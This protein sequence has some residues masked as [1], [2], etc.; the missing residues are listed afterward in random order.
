[1]PTDADSESDA[2]AAA[3]AGS[4]ADLE[5]ESAADLETDRELVAIVA[6]A[7]NGVIGRDGEMPWHLPEDLAHFKETTTDHPVIMGRVTYEGIL[8]TLGEPLPGR[9]TVV[10]TSRDLEPPESGAERVRAANG[11]EEALEAAERAADERHGGAD[12]IFVA[13]GATVY[14]QFLPALDRLVVTEIRDEPEG[15]TRFPEWD[16]DEWTEVSR[17]E[18]DGFAFLEYVRRT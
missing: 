10:L 5:A 7:E 17:D 9:T 14:E 6:V 8:E 1:M 11:L 13:G 3:G 12:R 18:R 15:D 16:R 2:D 4:A